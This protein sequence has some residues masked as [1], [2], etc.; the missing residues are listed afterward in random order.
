MLLRLKSCLL[1]LLL[2]AALLSSLG[3]SA[4]VERFVEGVHYS[5]LPDLAYARTLDETAGKVDVMEIFWYGCGH[6][7]AF[8][9]LL[10]SWADAQAASINFSRSPLMVWSAVNKQHARLFFAAQQ[11]DKINELHSIIFTEIQERRNPL[12]DEQTAAALFAGHGV[13]P[14]DF[15]NAYNSFAVD[16][17]LRKAETMQKEIRIPSVP[18]MIVSGKYRVE[19][20]DA[21]TSHEAMLEVVE[22][23]V[24]K[25]KTAS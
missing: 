12:A 11:L 2:F 13:L 17:L 21:V 15:A 18:V 7:Y 1:N 24:S 19:V 4:Q 20:N 6:C 9:P 22:F 5:A 16:T 8:D 3:A 14:A 23:L 25:E 10:E